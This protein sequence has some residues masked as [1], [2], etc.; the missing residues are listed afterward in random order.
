M[1][2]LDQNL[3]CY[4]HNNHTSNVKHKKLFFSV[5]YVSGVIYYVVFSFRRLLF[6]PHVFRQYS[7]ISKSVKCHYFYLTY[8]KENI[9]TKLQELYI[10]P[11]NP[12]AINKSPALFEN[13]PLCTGNLSPPAK[14]SQENLYMSQ[15]F[16]L[17]ITLFLQKN[18]THK[19]QRFITQ[20][21]QMIVLENN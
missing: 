15:L 18:I 7:I 9:I 19:R 21:K 6:Q 10:P 1:L 2:I 3:F 12:R 11:R 16:Q 20:Q 4:S 8:I 14:Y 17:E 13:K 5:V